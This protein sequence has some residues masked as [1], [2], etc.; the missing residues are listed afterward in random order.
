MCPSLLITLNYIAGQTNFITLYF[1]RYS[2]SIHRLSREKHEGVYILSFTVTSCTTMHTVST[3]HVAVSGMY[4]WKIHLH[5]L[6]PV[7]LILE[8][9]VL[10]LFVLR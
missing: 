2:I 6:V 5:M 9:Y 7:R 8:N 10:I 1:F 4:A 3:V